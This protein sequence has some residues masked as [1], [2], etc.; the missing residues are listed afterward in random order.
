M[1]ARKNLNEDCKVTSK[2]VLFSSPQT[3]AAAQKQILMQR[4]LGCLQDAVSADRCIEIEPALVSYQPHIA[5]ATYTPSKCAA[6]CQKTCSG[7]FVLLQARGVRFVLDSPIEQLR[8]EAGAMVTVKT[9]AGE[10]SADQYVMALGAA[11]ALMARQPGIALPIYPLRGYSITVDVNSQAHAP[12]VSVT[13]SSR[14]VVFARIGSR[15]R[16]AGMAELAGYDTCVNQKQIESL[17]TSAQRCSRV[18]ARL[19]S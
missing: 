6:D 9:S 15:L 18:S 16:V 4:E 12:T 8:V 3:F 10:V 13:D 7:L 5:G 19:L 2:L 1:L 11:S 14:K 17:K